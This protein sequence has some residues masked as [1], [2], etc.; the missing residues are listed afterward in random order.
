MTRHAVKHEVS[1]CALVFTLAACSSG[2]AS[3]SHLHDA[4]PHGPLLDGGAGDGAIKT[5]VGDAAAALD[6]A[7]GSGDAGGAGAARH[8]RLATT[9]AQLVVTGPELGLQLTAANVV[10]D[11]DVVSV[12][13]E[14]YG[15]PWDAF[16]AQTAPPPE[17]VAV[18]DRFAKAAHDANKPVF[19]SISML[20]GKR[21]SLAAQTTIESGAVK[22]TDDWSA[23][24]Y[25]F[26][27]A[28]DAAAKK[29]AYLRYVAYMVDKFTP[30]HLNLAI[31]VNLFFEK[32]PA[33]TAGLVDVINA[34]YDQ[35]KAKAPKT[36]VFP[37]IQ[38]DHLYG[39]STDSCPDQTK[40]AACFDQLY[41]VLAP[42]KRDRFAMSSYPYMQGIAKPSDIPADWFMRGAARGHEIPLIAETG[43]P[44]TKV[45]VKAKDGTC[46]TYF[47]FDEKT[48]ADY[49]AR[50]LSDADTG[51]LELVTWWSDRD[52]L[53][54]KIMTNCPCDFDAT[55]C[56]VL[57]IFRG[58]APT[59]GT[60]DSQLFGEL[61]LKVFGTMGIRNYD[62]TPKA[63]HMALWNAA[64]ARSYSP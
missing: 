36:L 61:L 21:E 33:A 45:V 27:T 8:F 38:I 13:Q 58:P 17:W 10:E 47:S 11:S 14:F 55:W 6:G 59:S 39:Y 53:V 15:V 37:S 30:S 46:Q 42:I 26:A 48:S 57:D 62:G 5:G 1:W 20:N 18:M 41:A 16:E 56:S 31:E 34:A 2:S 12:H 50:V 4:G 23:K 64:R 54:A 25:D 49:L 7:L 3:N 51:G 43:W 22:S 19:L 63:M 24:C 44:S 60:F 28:P 40:R 29:A 32:C 35:V 9:G 52:L